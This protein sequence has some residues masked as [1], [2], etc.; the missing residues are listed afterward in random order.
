MYFRPVRMVH[1]RFRT[2]FNIS[3]FVFDIHY[4]YNI[5]IFD[6]VDIQFT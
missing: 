1:L 3:Q 6:K 2:I 5:D 4:H